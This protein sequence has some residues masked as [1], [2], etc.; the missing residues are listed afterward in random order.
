[1]QQI[2]ITNFKG[3]AQKSTTAINLAQYLSEHGSVALIDDD[4]NRS[5]TKLG[6]RGDGLPFD[7]FSVQQAMKRLQ[8]KQPDYCVIDTP[9][10]PD[11]DEL[12]DYAEDSDLVIVPFSP[13]IDDLDPTLE[14][15]NQLATICP[16]RYRL[17]LAKV[18]PKPSKEGD[19][20]QGELIE[21]GYPLF[22]AMIRRSAGIPRAALAGQSVKLQTGIYRHAWMD[23]QALGAEVLALLK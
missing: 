21:A 3:G 10:R 11:S 22:T 5:V 16:G 20:M 1:M 8:T 7:V 18:P 2:L 12:K 23:Y 17:L 19:A 14:T 4:P 13:S 6:Q 9:A 15:A